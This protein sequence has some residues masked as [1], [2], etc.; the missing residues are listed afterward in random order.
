MKSGHAFQDQDLDLP[1]CGDAG[2]RLIPPAPMR[3]TSCLVTA[4]DVV[5]HLRNGSA[6][7]SQSPGR[8]PTV[9]IAA[10][11]RV[12]SR[13]YRMVPTHLGAEQDGAVLHNTSRASCHVT[14]RASCHGAAP[15]GSGLSD[16]KLATLVNFV[17]TLVGAAAV[18]KVI[19]L[20]IVATRAGRRAR[21]QQGV[22][23]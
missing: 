16:T 23:R 10:P 3:A 12:A 14:S 19:D 4:A 2:A 17:L 22:R 6:P 11:T 5:E 8:A 7:A 15:V 20:D 18:A 13:R 21:S 1:H 9:Q